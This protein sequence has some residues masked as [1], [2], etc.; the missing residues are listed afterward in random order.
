[1][2]IKGLRDVKAACDPF[3]FTIVLTTFLK[4]SITEDLGLLIQGGIG[5]NDHRGPLVEVGEQMKEA[6]A[7]VRLSG[8][9]KH[10]DVGTF[11]YGPPISPPLNVSFNDA[12]NNIQ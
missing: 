12:E 2:K 9:L 10:Q 6:L 11:V 5:G 3:L 4:P 7:G 8:G 1:M